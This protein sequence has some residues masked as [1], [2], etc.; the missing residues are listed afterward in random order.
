MSF[1]SDFNLNELDVPRLNGML[2]VATNLKN[3]LIIESR[4]IKNDYN[5]VKN[6]YDDIS[7]QIRDA[8]NLLKELK[9]KK[10]DTKTKIREYKNQYDSNVDKISQYNN[11]CDK[12]RQTITE[13]QENQCCKE[14][15]PRTKYNRKADWDLIPNGTKIVDKYKGTHTIFKKIQTGGVA[16][17][18]K[19]GRT[20]IEYY[21]TISK[22]FKENRK[23]IQIEL[24]I[25]K[26][27]TDCSADAWLNLELY[28][29]HN[30]RRLKLNEYVAILHDNCY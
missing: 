26:S 10:E 23:S 5:N 14:R 17:I 19:K 18:H 24:G 16:I 13:K 6:Q 25:Y 7:Q 29:L 27:T 20:V 9:T 12:I 4:T 22:A 30:D 3:E 21:D 8:E 2:L 15:K 1:L 28:E 11:D